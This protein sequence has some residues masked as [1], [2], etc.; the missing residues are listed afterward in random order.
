MERSEGDVKNRWNT[1]GFRELRKALSATTMQRMSQL[2]IARHAGFPV[3]L[4]P[5]S[6]AI[7]ISSGDLIQGETGSTMPLADS[8]PCETS[9]GSDDSA[10]DSLQPDVLIPTKTRDVLLFASSKDN[11]KMQ[12]DDDDD[13][14]IAGL[15]AQEMSR[16]LPP[17]SIAPSPSWGT[18]E[19]LF[20]KFDTTSLGINNNT[21]AAYQWPT[22]KP[23]LFS[24]V[25]HLNSGAPIGGRVETCTPSVHNSYF[26]HV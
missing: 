2:I 14:S 23:I 24:P 4:L 26:P 22:P 10:D 13:G 3:E 5:G 6:V 12:D 11:D 19:S 7:G 25:S 18:D 1:K 20:G 9:V 15:V 21:D 16:E 17:L 8:A